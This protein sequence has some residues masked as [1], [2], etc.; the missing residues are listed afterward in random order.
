MKQSTPS[1]VGACRIPSEQDAEIIKILLTL[2]ELIAK[3]ELFSQ[4]TFTWGKKKKRSVLV[5]KSEL[6]PV[7]HHRSPE[8]LTAADKSPSTPLCFLPCGNGSDGY[9]NPKEMLA[10]KKSL[11]RKVFLFY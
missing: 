8:K 11:K 7:T 9:D 6:S 1:R 4:Y 2:P 5:T 10:L 3:K